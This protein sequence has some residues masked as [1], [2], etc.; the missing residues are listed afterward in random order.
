MTIVFTTVVFVFVAAV[1]ALAAYALYECTPFRIGETRIAP[2]GAGSASRARTSTSFRTT[3][4]PL[5]RS[6]PSA[7]SQLHEVPDDDLS[8]VGPQGLRTLAS[9]DGD[10]DGDL[11][12]AARVEPVDRRLERGCV[13][14]R[15]ADELA[16]GEDRVRCRLGLQVSAPD[17][18]P[19]HDP[20]DLLGEPRSSKNRFGVRARGKHGTLHAC[21]SGGIEVLHRARERVDSSVSSNAGRPGSSGSRARRPFRPRRDRPAV[22]PVARSPGSRGTHGLHP[23]AACRGDRGSSPC[24]H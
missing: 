3:P 4:E 17:D 23:D 24:V 6:R 21:L 19:V 9:V 1:L 7:S 8:A 16:G 22:P 11:R 10:R 2:K 15:H 13:A 18:V 12:C 5:L 14:G 20:I